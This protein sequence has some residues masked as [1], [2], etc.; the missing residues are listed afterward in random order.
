MKLLCHIQHLHGFR[1]GDRQAGQAH[2][3]SSLPYLPEA[4]ENRQ[5]VTAANEQRVYPYSQKH[6]AGK[7]WKRASETARGPWASLSQP[8]SPLV[9]TRWA[10]IHK[11]HYSF[12]PSHISEGLELG[13]AKVGSKQKTDLLHYSQTLARCPVSRVKRPGALLSLGPDQPC[14]PGES[15]FLLAAP[16]LHKELDSDRLKI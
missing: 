16:L 9:L 6:R 4:P 15:P 10:T 5:V 8:P 12:L 11:T 14:D 1:R 7:N 2:P 13:R 3:S